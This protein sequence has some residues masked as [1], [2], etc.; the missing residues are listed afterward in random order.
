MGN[1][2]FLNCAFILFLGLLRD[3]LR[4][5]WLEQIKSLEGVKAKPHNKSV[6]ELQELDTVSSC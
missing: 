2:F 1:V 6:R 3:S 5:Y 4:K